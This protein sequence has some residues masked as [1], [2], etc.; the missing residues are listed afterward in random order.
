MGKHKGV[1][2][3]AMYTLYTKSQDR[4]NVSNNDQTNCPSFENAVL[5]P[6]ESDIQGCSLGP[7]NSLAAANLGP[8]ELASYPVFYKGSVVMKLQMIVLYIGIYLPLLVGAG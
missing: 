1:H 6:H 2:L 4:S 7:L 5:G 3:D 8:V